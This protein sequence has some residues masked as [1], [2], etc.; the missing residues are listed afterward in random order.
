MRLAL[1]TVQFGLPYGIANQN[2]QPSKQDAKAILDYAFAS[3]VDT[4]DTAIVYGQSE[5]RLGEIGI[6]DWQVISKLPAIPDGCSDVRQWV[7]ESV[8]S[9]L[10]RMGIDRL[11][12]LL[13]HRPQQLLSAQGG[14]LFSAME[15]LKADG[16]LVKMGVSVYGFEEL[17]ALAPHYRFDLVQAPFNVLDQGLLRSGWMNRMASEGTELHVR[18]LFLQGLLLMPAAARP[19]KFLR[20]TNVWKAWDDWLIESGLTPLQ[21]CIRYALSFEQI[22]KAVIG[23]DNVPQLMQIIEASQGGLTSPLPIALAV[24]DAELTN[25]SRWNP[26]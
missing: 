20:W 10:A 4:L 1:G 12:G 15:S 19:E 17:D 14:Q 5:V 11:H 2:G 24:D 23:V 18:S 8:Q 3:G 21:A 13:L 6:A 25:P 9:S 7:T 16:L 22:S 26:I